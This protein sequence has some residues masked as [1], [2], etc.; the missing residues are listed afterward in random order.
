MA[1]DRDCVPG[2]DASVDGVGAFAMSEPLGHCIY[3]IVFSRADVGGVLDA[4]SHA[5]VPRTKAGARHVLTVPAVRAMATDRRLITIA[6][7]YVGS[8]AT[9]F[10]ATLFDKSADANWAC[11]MR[12]R[13]RGPSSR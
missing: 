11:C 10:R 1:G 7:T 13:R 6:S 5:D 4:L 2:L 8:G 9:P 12:A 3:E